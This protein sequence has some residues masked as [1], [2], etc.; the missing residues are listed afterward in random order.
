[1][2]QPHRGAVP[3]NPAR[4]LGVATQLALTSQDTPEHRERLRRAV[5]TAYYAIFHALANSNANTL[6]GAPTTNGG[7]EALPTGAA[8]GPPCHHGPARSAHPGPLRGTH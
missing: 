6:T 8:G 2:G 3:V 4:L 7:T 1:M 5:S